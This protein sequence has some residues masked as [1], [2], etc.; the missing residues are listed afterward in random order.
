MISV[1]IVKNKIYK[2]RN[3]LPQSTLNKEE[4]EKNVKGMYKAKKI[5]KIKN[6]KIL[7]FDDIYTTGETVNE[8]AKELIK[9]GIKRENIGVLTIA[10]D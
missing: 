7:I 1:K 10:K 3:N 6:K 5:E 2:T 9:K 4:R 8:C